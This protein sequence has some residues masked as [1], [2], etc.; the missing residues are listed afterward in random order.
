VA[1]TAVITIGS[2]YLFGTILGLQLPAGPRFF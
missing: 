1:L 2:W